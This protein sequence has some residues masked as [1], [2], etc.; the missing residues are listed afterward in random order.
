M[1][2]SAVLGDCGREAAGITG[3]RPVVYCAENPA[4]ALLEVLVHL[5]FGD[6]TELPDTYQ[7]LEIEVADTISRIVLDSAS[8]Q[9]DWRHQPHATQSIGSRWLADRQSA[10]LWVPSAI[11]P[12]TVNVLVNPLHPH[13]TLLR[14]VSSAR[15][16]FDERLIN[17]GNRSIDNG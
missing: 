4:A 17:G 3:A 2:I 8:L 6:L 16:P 10:L 14:R 11:V 9:E 13:A 12:H 5:E 7:L 1:Q 15:Y